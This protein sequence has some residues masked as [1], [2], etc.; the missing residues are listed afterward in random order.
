VSFTAT[1]LCVA[2]QRVFIFVVHFVSDSVR[3]LL[4]TTSSVFVI[5]LIL[6]KIKL[7]RPTSTIES[8]EFLDIHSIHNETNCPCLLSSS[9]SSVRMGFH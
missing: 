6:L 2:S 1:T 4:D 3:T 7:A 9:V 8:L 5:I